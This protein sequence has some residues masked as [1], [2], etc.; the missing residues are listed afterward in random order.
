MRIRIYEIVYPKQVAESG[1]KRVEN[2]EELR[3]ENG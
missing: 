3:T 1:Y 2:G